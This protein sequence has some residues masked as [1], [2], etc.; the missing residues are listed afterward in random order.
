MS[1]HRPETTDYVQRSVPEGEE[2][3]EEEE[4]NLSFLVKIIKIPQFTKN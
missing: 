3:E 4:E 2:E 1:F